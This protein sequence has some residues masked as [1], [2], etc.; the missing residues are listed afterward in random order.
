MSITT[1][2]KIR[3]I[4]GFDENIAIDDPQ[5]TTVILAIEKIVRDDVFTFHYKAIPS[6]NPD[7]NALWD[8][9]NTSFTISAPIA[10]HDFDGSTTNDVTGTWLDSSMASNDCSVTVTSARYGYITI[11]QDDDT[12]AI[13]ATAEA[14]HLDYYT[15]D[16]EIAFSDLEE[17][18]T[19]LGCH[20]V[21]QRLTQPN[22]ISYKDYSQNARL[23]LVD[24]TKFSKLYEH[25]LRQTAEP[26][27]AGC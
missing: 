10:D 23:L 14:I 11:K 8:G 18:G 16:Q 26:L 22:K 9:S 3:D 19:L 1:A 7:T 17:L 6:G 25:K 15:S 24:P 4:G 13:P 5:L 21:E 2:G 12:S 27:L 20:Y